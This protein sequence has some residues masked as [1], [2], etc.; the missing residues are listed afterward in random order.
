METL[1]WINHQALILPAVEEDYLQAPNSQSIAYYLK[2]KQ[3][4]IQSLLKMFLLY[5]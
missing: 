2:D 3:T 5:V 4:N 1:H